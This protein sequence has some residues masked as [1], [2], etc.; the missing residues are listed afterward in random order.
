[1]KLKNGERLTPKYI[2]QWALNNTNIL[3]M[4]ILIIIGAITSANFFSGS[5]LA[6]VMRQITVNGLLAV[7]CTMTLLV[8]GFDLSIGHNIL[9]PLL[10]GE[11]T[12]EYRCGLELFVYNI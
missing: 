4:F 6:N 1:M 8:N 5:N 10:V 11:M 12:G 2:G 9:S 7:A 3:L